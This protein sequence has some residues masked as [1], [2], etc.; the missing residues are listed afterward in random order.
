MPG[1]R[2]QELFAAPTPTVGGLI[3]IFR[4]KN[5]KRCSSE[6]SLR[7]KKVYLFRSLRRSLL[8]FKEKMLGIH[9]DKPGSSS[10]ELATTCRSKSPLI[11]N[12]FAC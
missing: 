11:S 5:A 6:E 2:A 3:N 7:Q 1:K 4:I 12:S 8:L 9:C 10:G